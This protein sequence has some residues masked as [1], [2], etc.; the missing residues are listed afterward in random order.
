MGKSLKQL[1]AEERRLRL[2]QALKECPA[3]KATLDL[4]HAFLA[5]TALGC[6]QEVLLAELGWMEEQGLVELDN[7][8]GV[9]LAKL[10][11]RGRDVADGLT[12]LTGVA[13]PAP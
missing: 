12:L 3:Y 4:L 11:Q 5:G 10:L 9:I 2:L 13:R 6:S 8:D 1:A 7:T